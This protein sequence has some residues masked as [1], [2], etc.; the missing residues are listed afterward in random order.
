MHHEIPKG[1]TGFH[2]ESSECE[3]NPMF[4]KELNIFIHF[5]LIVDLYGISKNTNDTK[6]RKESGETNY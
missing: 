1:E 2:I 4:D 5:P 3:C 6:F